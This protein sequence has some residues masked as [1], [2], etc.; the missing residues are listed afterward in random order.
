[1]STPARAARRLPWWVPTALAAL[2]ARALFLFAA[3]EPLLYSHPYNYFH[4]ALAILEHPRPWS[5]VLSSDAW[6]L[7]LGPWTIAPLYYLFLAGLMAVFGPHLLAIQVAQI[8][9]DVL[10]AVL[11]AHLGR[12]VAGRFGLWAGVV[13]AIDFHAIEQCTSTLTENVSNVLLLAGLVLLVEEVERR[14]VSEAGAWRA[15]R[16]MALAGGFVLGLSGLARSVATAFVPLAAAWRWSQGR[17]RLALARAVL[18]AAGAAAAVLPWTI[19]NA[20][21]TGDFVPVETN[22]IYNLYDDNTL[23]EGERRARQ[24]ALIRAQPTLAEQRSMA[25]RFALRGIAREPGALAEKAWRNLLH[26]VRPD[27]LQLLLVVEEPMPLWRQ[28]ALI[29]L[30]DAIVLP[31]VVLFAV[32][33]AASPRSPARGLIAAWTAYYLFMVVVVF[34]NEI[35]YR[36]TLLPLALA[37]AAGGLARLAR[38]EG[39]RLRLRAGLAVG[40][41]LVALVVA[42]YVLPALRAARA[43][44]ALHAMDVAASSGDRAEVVRQAERAARADPVASRPWL[45]LGG[46]LARAG[47]PAGALAAYQRAAE[48][49]PHVWVPT[50]V[51]PALLAAAGRTEEASQ[52][53]ETANAFSWNVDPWLA[54]EAAWRE[55]P[56]PM[57]D[58]VRLGRGDYGAARGFSNPR[59]DGRWSRHR[60]WLR[61]RPTTAAPAYEATL[62]MGSPLPSPLES[63]VVRVRTADG[64]ET[65]FTVSRAIAPYRVRAV[66]DRDGVVLVRL[67]AATWNRRG[68]PAEQGVSVDRLTVSPADGSRR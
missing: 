33:L 65:S 1:M 6:H 13:Y 29:V 44:P 24:E 28:A 7:W 14:S 55:L 58:E 66:P 50:V 63:A 4:G 5:F 21:V 52:A 59:R 16:W 47:D 57:T 43:W 22:G 38:G 56:A 54:L 51:A 18:I 48:R 2:L 26:L 8:L 35:R 34:H 12:R 30:D 32:F 17:D 60:A 23:V 15:G 19:R 27:G 9:L 68:E 37:G 25:L 61:V 49:K 20:V 62:W 45:R 41:V 40:G 67:D 42:P 3:D 10:A 64:T 31:A 53:V 11:T 39:G 36:S 46:L